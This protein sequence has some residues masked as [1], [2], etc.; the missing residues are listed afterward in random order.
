MGFIRRG[1]KVKLIVGFL[2]SDIKTYVKIKKDLERKYG[3]VDFESE[4]IDFIHT[5]YYADEMGAQLNRKF[6]SFEKLVDLGNICDV[7]IKTNSL[8]KR[9]MFNGKRSINIDPGYLNLSKVVLFSTKDYTHRLY[10]GKGIFAEVT[11]FFQNDNYNPWP[12]TYPDY[13][14]KEYMEIFKSI[15][16]I[17][18]TQKKH[19]P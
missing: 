9:F 14:T 15:R 18:K 17:Y 13:K 10:I 3:R 8:E 16:Q 4:A 6:L 7:K 12:W 5:S 1:E 11:L 19:N 2:F